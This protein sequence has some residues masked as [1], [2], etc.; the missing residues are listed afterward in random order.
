MAR[1]INQIFYP[2]VGFYVYFNVAFLLPP[3]TSPQSTAFRHP[4]ASIFIAHRPLA[5]L[6]IQG[7]KRGV[8]TS[9]GEVLRS[10]WQLPYGATDG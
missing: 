7:A 4:S 10:P 2:F 1:Q 5:Q 3:T 8:V 6:H 9:W